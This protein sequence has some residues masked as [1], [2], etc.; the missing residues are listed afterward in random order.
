MT[1]DEVIETNE[2]LRACRSRMEE[3]YDIA[4]KALVNLMNQYGESKS[5]KNIFNRYPLL[6]TM[7]K[8]IIWALNE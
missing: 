6:K 7:I 4:K 8:V 2:R 3:S 1:R 5:Q